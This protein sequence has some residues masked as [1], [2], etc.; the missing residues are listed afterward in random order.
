M[1]DNSLLMDYCD[2]FDGLVRPSEPLLNGWVVLEEILGQRSMR[3]SIKRPSLPCPRKPIIRAWDPMTSK[4]RASTSKGAVAS[5]SSRS[6]GYLNTVLLSTRP[7]SHRME[8]RLGTPSAKNQW[9]PMRRS[10]KL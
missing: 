5:V 2:S 4:S 6:H 1:M 8:A 10:D 7:I 3:C 9:E